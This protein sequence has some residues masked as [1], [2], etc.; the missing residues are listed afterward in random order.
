MYLEQK[1][2]RHDPVLV[3][4]LHVGGSNRPVAS[5]PGTA[6]HVAAVL[7]IRVANTNFRCRTRLLQ[8]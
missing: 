2:R 6:L 5:P 8:L 3:T 7:P 1:S 4:P